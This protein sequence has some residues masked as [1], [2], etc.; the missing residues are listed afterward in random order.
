MGTLIIHPKNEEQLV[1]LKAFMTAFKI[2]FEEEASPYNA[3]FVA[4]MKLS[5]QQA[6]K[7][8]TVKVDLDDIWK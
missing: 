1:A 8:Q 6:K 2:S 3:D 7:G 4:K 5:K